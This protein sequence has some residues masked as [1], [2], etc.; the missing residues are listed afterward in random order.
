MA[1]INEVSITGIFRTEQVSPTF[2]KQILEVNSKDR[3]GQWRPAQLDI[4]IKDDLKASSGIQEGLEMTI[5]GWIAFNFASGGR[6]FPKVIVT[7]ISN[8]GQPQFQNQ[9][10]PTTQNAAGIPPVPGAAPVAPGQP[11]AP[12]NPLPNQASQPVAPVAP[13]A[14]TA[15]V[16]PA[17]PGV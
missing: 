15:P 1:R 6:S 10:A 7:E 4:Y 14:P 12:V 9:A 2:T 16:A 8:V 3:D 11:T 13:V 5:K 17:V